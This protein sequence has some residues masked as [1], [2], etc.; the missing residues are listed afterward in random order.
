MPPQSLSAATFRGLSETTNG[1]NNLESR[2]QI[3]GNER[4]QATNDPAL[5]G[6]GEFAKRITPNENTAFGALHLLVQPICIQ[7]FPGLNFRPGDLGQAAESFPNPRVD[8]LQP[9]QN[10]VPE[11]VPGEGEIP[12]A[13]ID[14]ERTSR[15]SQ[16]MEHLL[17]CHLQ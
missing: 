8:S 5:T 14:P 16:E 3:R 12:V 9:G 13:F 2:M 6:G 10:F 7:T 1:V 11:I 15:F 17:A 4:K